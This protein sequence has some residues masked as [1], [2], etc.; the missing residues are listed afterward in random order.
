MKDQIPLEGLAFNLLNTKGIVPSGD[1]K[2]SQL[3]EACSELESMFIYYLLKE[4]RETVPKDGLFSGG[5]TEQMYTS[6]FDIQLAN[7]IAAKRS[8][9]ISSILFDQMKSSAEKNDGAELKN[10]NGSPVGK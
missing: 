9:G 4:M 7:E 8:I 3:R 10:K 2:D 5:K 1:K 6:F